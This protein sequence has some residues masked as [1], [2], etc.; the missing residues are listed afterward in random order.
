[1]NKTK[2]TLYTSALILTL[3]VTL[4]YTNKRKEYY[5]I[6][7][8]TNTITKND[9]LFNIGKKLFEKNYC[10]SCH[11]ID[12]DKIMTAP[13]LGGITKRRDQK[14]LYKYTRNS[15]KMYND[16][17]SIAIE[18]RKQG[19]GLMESFPNLSDSDLHD[20]YYFVE[21]KYN[22]SLSTKDS[23]NSH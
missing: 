19:W 13:A 23:L 16:K 7:N 20:I 9:S 2:K 22:Q 5:P 15:I 6:K 12:M 11:S 18:L 10:S 8:R 14:W 3:T 17:D 1:M 21:K 4:A